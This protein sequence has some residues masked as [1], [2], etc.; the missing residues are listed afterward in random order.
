M[1][2]DSG[3]IHEFFEEKFGDGEL[4]QGLEPFSS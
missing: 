4:T 3:K 2:C 1:R